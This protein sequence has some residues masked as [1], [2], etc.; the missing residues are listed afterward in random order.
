MLRLL[1]R[2]FSDE[3][4]STARGFI[5]S[6]AVWMLVGT[7]EGLASA[8]H[9]VAPDTFTGIS[10][11]EFGRIRP[12]HTNTV[13][14][15]FVTS[16][17]IGASL[18]VLTVVLRRELWSERLGKVSLWVW[19]LA[20][21]SGTVALLMGYTQGREY[22]EL[23]WP[24]DVL[25][26]IAFATLFINVTMTIINRRE[27]LLYVSVWYIGATFFW[28]TI[29]YP[30]GNVMWHPY[31]GAMSGMVDAVWLWFYGHNIFGFL[32]TPLATAILY[33]MIP[34]LVR[35]PLYSHVLSLVG[36]WG[37]VTFYSHIGTHHLM[38]AP[39]PLWLKAVSAIDSFAMMLPVA[40]VLINFWYTARG[41]FGVL[42]SSVSGKLAFMSTIWYLI[43]C[44]QGPIQSLPS[45]QRVTH[46]TNWV[47]GHAHIAVLG[48][49]GFAAL[50]GQFYVLPLVSR[51][52]LYSTAMANM[53]FWLVMTGLTGFFAVL[54]AAGLVQGEAWRN[55][56]T[57]YRVLPEIADYMAMRAMFG[58]T[59]IAGAAIGLYNVIMTM[60]R[61]E[62]LAPGE[63]SVP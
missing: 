24:V 30:Q 10:F 32:V 62:P 52:R 1:R 25:V 37:L 8:V 59:I 39:A 55:G 19:N 12:G 45:I 35:Q 27:N 11:L 7:L 50:A 57:V 40:T 54:T 29:I 26:L 18:Y 33:Y 51:R 17:L 47:V 4:H 23:I 36:F 53:E 16:Q 46:F 34:R 5:V 38:Q 61:G 42:L 31:T 2:M 43:T 28:M 44:I 21:A 48:F 63:Y 49:T 3:V 41:K 60:Y 15:G 6:G 14:F 9:L 13:L 22:A 20:L 58:I 56:E